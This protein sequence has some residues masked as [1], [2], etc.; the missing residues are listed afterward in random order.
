MELKLFFDIIQALSVIIASIIAYYG[1]SSWRKETMWKRKYE[2]AEEVLSCFYEVSEN[3]DTIRNPA[4]YVGEGKTRKRNENESPEESKIL[5]SAYVVIERFEKVKAPFIKLKSLK[6]RFMV[7]FGKE[8]EKPFNKII[9]LTNKLFLASHRLG[10]KYWK[11]QVRQKFTDEKFDYHLK[12]M[13]EQEAIFW[14]D[15]GEKEDVFKNDV[16]EVI[17]EI[18]N[19]CQ[20]IIEKK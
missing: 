19:I 9:K 10:Y 8:S 12:K 14:A 11:D 2:L 17:S 15:F 16:D 4:G 7:L 6:Y 1:I 3:F 18:E 20:K 5:D 13:H